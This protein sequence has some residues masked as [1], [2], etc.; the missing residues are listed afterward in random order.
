LP[1][2]NI[3]LRT[4]RRPTERVEIRTVEFSL[5][6]VSALATKPSGS[7]LAAFLPSRLFASPLFVAAPVAL[8]STPVF[9]SSRRKFFDAPERF[10]V[11]DV[12][13]RPV[14]ELRAAV[15][16]RSR[17]P[18]DDPDLAGVVRDGVRVDVRLVVVRTFRAG[19]VFGVD[20]PVVGVFFDADESCPNVTLGVL[21]ASATTHQTTE[22]A[23]R[24]CIV[25][26]RRLDC[27]RWEGPTVGPRIAKSAAG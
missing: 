21:K 6:K 24:C 26:F 4:P 22:N 27:E 3:Q 10:A 7:F 5:T 15:R 12:F 9:L 1:A 13:E 18:V 8:F 17:R 25:N 23:T 20:F 19:V 2:R 14:A 16:L 11:R